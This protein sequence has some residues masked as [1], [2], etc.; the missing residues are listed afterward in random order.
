MILKA[1]EKDGDFW[2]YDK[3][4]Y[5]GLICPHGAIE[6]YQLVMDG[7]CLGYAYTYKKAYFKFLIKYWLIRI[8]KI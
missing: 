6:P 2:L 5:V 8:F 1:K 4:N 7:R 3:D